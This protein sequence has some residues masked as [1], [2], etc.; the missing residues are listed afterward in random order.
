MI[1]AVPKSERLREVLAVVLG[2]HTL[3]QIEDRL[4]TNGFKLSQNVIWRARRGYFGREESLEKLAQPYAGE[5]RRHFGAD[6]RRMFGD[7]TA[8]ACAHWLVNVAR[9]VDQLAAR[10]LP[11]PQHPPPPRDDP[12]IS[13]EILNQL[14]DRVAERV[15]SY[16]VMPA[17]PEYDAADYLHEQLKRLAAKHGRRYIDPTPVFTGGLLDPDTPREQID[18]MI[19]EL[20]QAAEESRAR[21]AAQERNSAA[22]ER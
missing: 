7:D 11:E 18:A 17:Q 15:A 12:P 16:T 5:I 1:S 10:R 13:L 21:E 3:S 6:V 2:D 14:A 20:D 9:G 4:A 22:T 19:A 8:E